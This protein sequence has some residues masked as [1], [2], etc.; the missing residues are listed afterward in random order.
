MRRLWIIAH[1][2]P[3][4]GI[5]RYVQSMIDAYRALGGEIILVSAGGLTKTA[6]ET[7]GGRVN[8]I[9]ERENL[10]LDFASWR[11]ALDRR[12]MGIG[13]DEIIITNDS[14][15]GPFSDI[16]GI[17]AKIA[18]DETS[19]LGLTISRQHSIHIQSYFVGFNMRA[20]PRE[21][22]EAFWSDVRPLSDKTEIIHKYEIGLSQA[23]LAAGLDLSAIF[24]ARLPPNE[25][26]PHSA[27]RQSLPETPNILLACQL[28][29]LQ[30]SR[31]G[32]PTMNNWHEVMAAGVPYVKV[33]LLRDNPARLNRNLVL[34]AIA[35]YGERPISEVHEHLETLSA[36]H[37][38]NSSV[39]ASPRR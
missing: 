34:R 5:A 35:S 25:S 10:G 23:A 16:S 8:E 30:S 9:I 12:E 7:L 13:Y 19:I 11:A 22:F 17:V 32:N 27:W 26:W 24:D 14:V 39:S 28:A 3:Q 2:D 18:R 15:F 29:Y 37:Q 36:R 20:F 38:Q 6:R 33:E 1:Y 4:H 31:L 21:V